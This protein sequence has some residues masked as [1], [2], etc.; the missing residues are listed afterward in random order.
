M[1]SSEQT[2]SISE[3]DFTLDQEIGILEFDGS[4]SPELTARFASGA[5]R[6]GSVYV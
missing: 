5:G 6:H 2:F 1:S 4:A 3:L